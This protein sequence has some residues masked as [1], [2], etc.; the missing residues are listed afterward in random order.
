MNNQNYNKQLKWALERGL[1]LDPR[2]V[3][4]KVGGVYGLYAVDD[5]PAGS[6]LIGYPVKKRIQN[7][8]DSIYPKGTDVVIKNLHAS[9]VEYAKGKNSDY[10][11]HFLQFENIDELKRYSVF[12]FGEKEHD[13]VKSMNSILAQTIK[14]I[15]DITHYR[16]NE[17]AK[18]EPSINPEVITVVCLNYSSRAWDDSSFLPILDY[19]NHS[20]RL[21]N[22]RKIKNNEYVIE[23][24]G[25][26]KKGEQIFISYSRKDMYY[27]ATNYNYFDASGV[28]CIQYGTRLIQNAKTEQEKAMAEYT[29][30]KFDILVS[31]HNNII[32]YRCKD[33]EVCFLETA[34]SLKLIDYIRTNFLPSLSE[35]K[36]KKCNDISLYKRLIGCIDFLLMQNKVD[37]FALE[38]MP[39][40]VERF[41]RL[42]LKEKTMLRK[43]K[44]WVIDNFYI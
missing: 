25:A 27:H 41:Y 11:G 39:E 12:F 43:N 31:S 38:D 18:L 2:V 29:A 3:R 14:E 5:I 9:V 34:P 37:E 19:A 21:G 23:A 13:L 10:Y 15:N 24:K 17:I 42:L 8:N 4:K 44:E 33:P 35:W 36:Q 7:F 22:T 32:Y 40:S 26:Y 1:F 6:R 30:S 16:V 20:D 28:H